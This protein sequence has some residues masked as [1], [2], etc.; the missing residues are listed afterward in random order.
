MLAEVLLSLASKAVTSSISMVLGMYNRDLK[1][2]SDLGGLK[3][4]VQAV[5]WG[6]M[7]GKA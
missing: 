3:R 5:P 2:A 6:A 1:T 7:T 4:A